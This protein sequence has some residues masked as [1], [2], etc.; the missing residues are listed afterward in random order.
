VSEAA[1]ETGAERDQAT[2]NNR[3]FGSGHTRLSQWSRNQNRT[4][5]WKHKKLPPHGNPRGA[6]DDPIMPQLLHA[7]TGIVVT[8]DVLA[9][10]IFM[11]GISI[12]WFSPGRRPHAKT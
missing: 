10:T 6:Q 2:S 8:D 7:V 4:N 5:A 11:S 1:E 3:P 12:S 9:A